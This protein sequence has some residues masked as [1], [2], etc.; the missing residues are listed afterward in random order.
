[1]ASRPSLLLACLAAGS[2]ASCLGENALV[3][4]AP[5]GVLA[6]TFARA[7]PLFQL[8]AEK[9]EVAVAPLA[10]EGEV[11]PPESDTEPVAFVK[12]DE[13]LEESPL[14]DRVD[15]DR[16][17]AATTSETYVYSSPS[18]GSTK[19]GYLRGGAIV[20][21]SAK[22]VAYGFCK[23]G[24]YQIAPEGY[25]CVGKRA[26]LDVTDALVQAGSRRPDRLAVL[27]YAYG[28]SLFP[29]PP[30]YTKVP[31]PT[32]Q[33]RVELE[34]GKRQGAIPAAGWDDVT[35]TAIP[36]MLTGG[37]P[38]LTWAG[39]RHSP[40]STH[41]GRAMPKSGFAFLSFF[42]SEG[43][44][45]GLTVD[46]DVVPLD[47]MRRVEPSTFRGI[48]LD[49]ETTLPVAFVLTKYAKL[50]KGEPGKGFTPERDLAY[51]EAVPI[52]G[53]SISISGVRYL[54]TRSGNWL[55]DESLTRVNAMK[56]TPGWATPGRTWIDV[57]ILKQTLI[58]YE[59]TT[60]VY[61]TLVSTGADGLGDPKDT[62]STV[63]GQFLIHTKH[64]TAT[65]SGD[66]LGDEFDLR[67]VPYVQYF[68]EGYALHAAYW[69]DS[70]GKPRSHGCINVSPADARWLFHWTDP[71]VP[72]AWHG[73]M[74]LRNGTLVYVHP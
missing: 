42:E 58:A 7:E 14:A 64:V 40:G 55:R 37:Q 69:H 73:A 28:M 2:L 20:R 9:V 65:M 27:P 24:W 53:K 52:T 10:S 29:T 57:S 36:N 13:T 15:A 48:N 44:R 26:T 39:T 63:R 5:P 61:V 43:R 66:E 47:R 33:R 41:S 4:F 50:L 49:S 68:R 67:D 35:Y 17:L 45:F 12:S 3:P 18:Y 56:N 32:D 72:P 31:S 51:R 30:F 60:P 25:V 34:L 21:R 19:I 11:E 6:R 54:E 70:F 62:H 8:A 46:L 74:S 38:S 23:Q 1:M 59:G 71:P 22:P 16:A